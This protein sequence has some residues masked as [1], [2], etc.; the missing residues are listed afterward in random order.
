MLVPLGLAVL[1]QSLQASQV[2]QGDLFHPFQEMKKENS[3]YK[4][5]SGEISLTQ[6][7]NSFFVYPEFQPIGIVLHST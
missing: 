7:V 1:F 6:F 5:V 4:L 2:A 3:A